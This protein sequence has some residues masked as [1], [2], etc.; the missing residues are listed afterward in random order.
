MWKNIL[1][2]WRVI[3]LKRGISKILM[4]SPSLIHSAAPQERLEEALRHL[5]RKSL[6]NDKKSNLRTMLRGSR[7]QGVYVEYFLAEDP[8]EF[9]KKLPENQAFLTQAQH[10]GLDIDVLTS[11]ILDSGIELTLNPKDPTREMMS[12][13]SQKTIVIYTNALARHLTQELD[14][15]QTY[16][17]QVQELYFRK[18][19][20]EFRN[21]S[22]R[23]IKQQYLTAKEQEIYR[24]KELGE[25]W[26]P[27]FQL[28]RERVRT[29]AGYRAQTIIES[30]KPA[31]LEDFAQLFTIY[32]EKGQISAAAIHE[33]GFDLS[34]RRSVRKLHEILGKTANNLRNFGDKYSD[35]FI[36]S[37]TFPSKDFINFVQD[38]LWTYKTP[39]IT[40]R[41]KNHT[42]A[43]Y[44]VKLESLAPE[45]ID[46]GND[47]GCCIAIYADDLGKGQDIPFYQLDLATPIFGIYQ[48]LNGKNPD[49]VGMI[50]SFATLNRSSHPVLLQNSTEL[51]QAQNPLAPGELD[52]LVMHTTRYFDRFSKAAGF[53]RSAIGT[54]DFN[55]GKNY[56][57][58]NWYAIP[59]YSKDELVKLPDGGERDFEPPEFYSQVFTKA[60][61]SKKGH[62]GY[63]R[64]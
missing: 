13:F 57:N 31:I 3:Y 24:G 34:Q 56:L 42:K 14:F 60:G 36:E 53:K 30:E 59:D 63:L 10:L 5:D 39:I 33:C 16:L 54:G 29:Q 61:F 43:H 41:V 15:F 44:F 25:P 48:K 32:Q 55:T 6:S 17:P 37:H 23:W 47:A 22:D 27:L 8:F 9:R 7:F 40:S 45:D 28:I 19:E 2:F 21:K 49:R 26:T 64:L 58:P 4:F 50:L 62:W 52:R 38:H 20:K 12:E 51:S 18:G 11:G 1:Y 46:I 35:E